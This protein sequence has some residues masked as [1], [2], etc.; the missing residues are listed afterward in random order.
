MPGEGTGE[1]D[2][3]VVDAR[4]QIDGIRVRST[5]GV[6]EWTVHPVETGHVRLIG[7]GGGAADQLLEP[8]TLRIRHQHGAVYCPDGDTDRLTDALDT[9]AE[10]SVDRRATIER[11]EHGDVYIADGGM[12]VA[13][14]EGS[15]DAI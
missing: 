1:V 3:A 5:E 12:D 7:V 4:E 10:A 13:Q 8:D 11:D 6:E 15:E 2:P 14:L 9:L